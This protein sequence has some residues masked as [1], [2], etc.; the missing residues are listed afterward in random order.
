MAEDIQNKVEIPRE[1]PVLPL[2]GGVVFPNLMVPLVVTTPSSQKLIDDALA[3]KRIVAAV[4]QK[5]EDI[6]NPGPDDLYS[7]GTACMIL[8]MLR[9]PD[10]NMRVL[11]QGLERVKIVKYTKTEPYLVAEVLVIKEEERESV[12]IEALKHNI[13]SMFQEIV[14]NSPYLPDEFITVALNIKEAG[15]LA[16]FIAS[17]MNIK[18]EEKQEILEAFDPEE[19]L[20][21][22]L[23]ILSRE[24]EVIKLSTKIQQQVKSELDKGQREYIL[25]EQLKAIQRELGIKDER[26][27]EISELREKIEAAGMPEEV[28]KV[29]LKELDRFSKIPPGSPEY[30]VSRTYLEWLVELPWSVETEDNLDLRRAENILKEDHYDL[31]KVRDRIL[32]F[33]AVRK[34]KKDTKGPILCFVG[35]PGVGKTSLGKS[36]ARALGRKFVRMSLGGI[37]DEAEIRGH[38]RTYIGALP[39]RIIQGIKQAGSK[40]PVF[41]LD[42]IDKVGMDFRGDPQAALLEVLDPEQNREFVDHYLDVP[43][44]LS[45]VLFIAT[46]NITAT[47]PPAL[48]DRMEVLELPGYIDEEKLFIARGYLIPR[49]IKENGLE[50]LD[51]SFTNTAILKIIREYTREAGVRNLER[52]IASVLRKIAKDYAMGN[53]KENKIRIGVKEIEKYLGPPQFYSEVKERK[54]EPGVVTGLAWT[55]TGGDILFIE[56]LKMPGGKRLILTGQLGDVM[57]ESAEAALSLARSLAGELGIDPKFYEKYDI[58]IHVPAGA[59]PKDGPSAGIAMFTALVSLLTGEAVDPE[60]AMTGEITL[61]GKVMPVGGIKEKVIAAKR[62]GIKRVILPRWNE[63]DLGEIPKHIRK[64]LDFIYVDNV[65]DVL[66]AVFGNKLKRKKGGKRKRG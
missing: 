42:E 4:T 31:E 39:G 57:K 10:G 19:R 34:L 40:N 37:R 38:R 41:M 54:G 63:K 66:R 1:V 65:R 13:L 51:I 15:K 60:L 64:G 28:K 8:K 2:K 29:A 22:L 27:A 59:I 47:I 62:A 12:E 23:P 20:K 56:A 53:L 18:T 6:E 32:E 9:T 16:D 55:P 61:R 24:L 5:K 26:E 25:R 3:S 30:T 45:R 33:L 17:Y 58:H 43:F 44:D 11:V 50:E 52:N 36:I 21:K 46:A 48:L 7:A 14:K 35:P 49:Q